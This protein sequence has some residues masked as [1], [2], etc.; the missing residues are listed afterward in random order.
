LLGRQLKLVTGD[1]GA[2][3]AEKIKAVGER[4]IG[5]KVDVV[6]TGYADSGVDAR[7]FGKYDMPFLHADVMTLDTEVVAQDPVK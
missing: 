7:V 3:E 1:V 6:I 5:E 4:L 2:L